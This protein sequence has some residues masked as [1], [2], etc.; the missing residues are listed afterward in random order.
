[1]SSKM[2]PP[3]INNSFLVDFVLMYTLNYVF[4]HLCVS[5]YKKITFFNDHRDG[6][7]L[8]F[9]NVQLSPTARLHA[10]RRFN[11]SLVHLR[12]PR[13]WTIPFIHFMWMGVHILGNPKDSYS[14][15][16]DIFER[17]VTPRAGQPL[18]SSRSVSIPSR[19]L[20][21]KTFRPNDRNI[22]A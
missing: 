17:K 16:N 20:A 3:A 2:V 11:A 13:I 9:L 21:R 5:V 8:T 7:F 4:T 18:A 1:M 12:L 15:R 6:I 14:G 19:W 22:S 10:Q